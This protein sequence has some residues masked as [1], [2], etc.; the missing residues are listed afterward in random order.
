MDYL[1]KNI[2]NKDLQ[3]AANLYMRS[4]NNSIWNEGWDN[5]LSLN[6]LKELFSSNFEYG[7]GCYL[8]NELIGVLIYELSS[9]DVGK[10]C[11]IKEMF[12]DPEYRRRGIGTG[13]ITALEKQCKENG[14]VSYSLWTANYEPLISFYSKFG[15][16][17]NHDIIQMT[18]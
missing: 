11:E 14:V 3:K 18:K 13:L 17:I 4:Y 8:E 6:R 1:Y 15:Y 7:I 2:E 12:V 16:R 5:N 10:Q 9:W